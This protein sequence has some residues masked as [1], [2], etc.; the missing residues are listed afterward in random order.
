M[1]APET[2]RFSIDVAKSWEK[3]FFES[4]TPQ[5]RKIALRCAIVMSP[6][7][8]GTFGILLGLVRRGLGGTVGSGK[9]F[10]SWVHDKDL[11]RAVAFLIGR[12]DIDGVVNISSPNPL[13]NREF[14]RVLREA[15]GARVGLPATEWMLEIAT[16]FMGTESEL[17]LKS[18]RVVPT[19]LLDAGFTFEFPQWPEA[20]ADLVRR[21]NARQML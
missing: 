14:M 6:H 5:T 13:P 3:T 9:Q 20:A 19:R 17:V 4:A 2:W 15:W 1:N 16:F 21:Y 8:A 18:R 10:V 11:A 12:E 7:R